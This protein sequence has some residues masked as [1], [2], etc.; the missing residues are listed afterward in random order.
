[1]PYGDEDYDLF[2]LNLRKSQGYNRFL[3]T[4]EIIGYIS[5]K[6]M[7]H[8]F[9]E[10]SSRNNGFIQNSYFEV[11]KAFYL[12]ELHVLLER[13]VQL[14]QWGEIKETKEEVFLDTKSNI[15]DLNKYKNFITRYKDFNL[16]FFK[17]DVDIDSANPEKQLDKLADETD[18]IDTKE[19]IK[20]IKKQYK[21]TK[22]ERDAE[23]KKR[24]Q[25]EN[26][27]KHIEKQNEVLRKARQ[28]SSYSEQISHHFKYMAEALFYATEDI[29]EIIT[30]IDQKNIVDKILE[31]ISEIRSTQKELIV[32][33]NLLIT[34][35]IDMR[36]NQ[37]INWYRQ[38]LL[39]CSEQNKKNYGIPIT[40][41]IDDE[42]S[43]NRWNIQCNVLQFQIALDNFYHN[44]RENNATTLNIFF[45]SDT[46][47]FESDSTPIDTIHKDKIFELGYS[48][49]P[50]GTGIGLYQIANFFNDS[51]FSIEIQSNEH[52]I[53]TI[54]KRSKNNEA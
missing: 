18:D 50:N 44:A 40:C 32:F 49:K 13:Y 28:S 37:T 42:K 5:I 21:E 8:H 20:R 4:R 23:Y 7:H 6:D 45:T 14:I 9:K 26:K 3:G 38:T 2:G 25:N 51:G 16:L 12:E 24:V 54:K 27:I 43:I 31:S 1:M 46:I 15:D 10:S 48:T 39:F 34:T 30:Q 19:T 36:S 33:Q 52:V 47:A 29:L 22:E 41:N 35:D 17:D 53:F 11:L